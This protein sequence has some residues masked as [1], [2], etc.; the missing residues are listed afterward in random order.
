MSELTLCNYH[1]LQRMKETAKERGVGLTVQ[2]ETEGEMR[3]WY[4]V[5]YSDKEE[6][7]AWFMEI[8]GKCVC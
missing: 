1:L 3:G 7:S 5:Q 8:T 4:A 2:L 6:P